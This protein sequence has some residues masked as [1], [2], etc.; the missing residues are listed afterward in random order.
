MIDQTTNYND[1]TTTIKLQATE[2]KSDL[3]YTVYRTY[4]TVVV[5]GARLRVEKG[6]ESRVR[7]QVVAVHDHEPERGSVSL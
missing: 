7:V 5:G 3:E 4:P 6:V 2:Y 1:Q